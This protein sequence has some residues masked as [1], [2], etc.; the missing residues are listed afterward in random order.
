MVDVSAREGR[1]YGGR[2]PEER[3]ADRRRRLLDAAVELFG[4]NGFHATSVAQLCRAARVAPAKFYDEFASTEELLIELSREI[5]T[6]V[7][8]RVLEAIAAVGPDVDVEAMA[9]AAV[10]AYCHGVLDD[11]RRARILCVEFPGLSPAAET[12]RR[13]QTQQFATLSLAGFQ[14]LLEQ[15]QDGTRPLDD[16][17]MALV[18][19]ALVGAIHEAMRHWL[20]QPEPRPSVDD[21]VEALMTVYTAVGVHL[22]T[23]PAPPP[24]G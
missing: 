22:L 7:R 19:T 3:R 21:V 4:T 17:Q 9:R 14:A 11:T 20:F 1:P 13:E 12:E 10:A 15:R 18:A 6:P 23:R 24:A 8:A 2:S 5:W 16:R